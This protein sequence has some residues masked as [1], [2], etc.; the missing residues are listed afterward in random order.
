MRKPSWRAKSGEEE[1]HLTTIPVYQG[2]IKSIELLVDESGFSDVQQFL[3]ELDASDRR[4]LDVLFCL[5]GDKGRI[6]TPEKFKKIEGSDGIFEFK[7]FQIR[8]LCFFTRDSRVIICKA[9]RKKKDRHNGQDISFA[10]ECKRRF[11]EKR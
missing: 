2:C 10:E 4:K 11:Q 6:A 9:L 3:D 5:M 7:S 1:T 8:L